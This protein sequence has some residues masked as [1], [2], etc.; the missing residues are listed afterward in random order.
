MPLLN[1]GVL[2][3]GAAGGNELQAVTRRAV[4][5][6]VVVQIGKATVSLSSLLA[7]AEPVVGG[8][9]PI[10]IPVQGVRMVAGAWADYSGQFSAPQVLPGLQNAEYNLKAF[11]VGIPYYLFEGFV[12]Q[13]AEIV[14]IIWARMNDAG[15]Y[16]ADQ[17]ATAL[18]AA[19]SANTSLMPFSIQDLIS[20]SNPTQGNVGNID[21]STNTFWQANSKSIAVIN[22]GSAA[23]SRVNALAAIQ[24]AQKASGGEPPSCLICSQG[25]FMAIAADTIGAESYL[26]DKEGTYATA[27]EG[28]TIAFP[29]LNVGGIPVYA[30]LYA[31]NDTQ[32][33]LP[34]FNYFQAKIHQEASF[35]IAGPE[36]LL[37]QFQLGY[38]MALFV[39]MEFVTS[40]SAAQ[41]TVTAFTGAFAI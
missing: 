14:P 38:V 30:D 31:P 11:V 2:P 33:W 24:Y 7:A 6:G 32:A 26:V 41:S 4:M 8:V 27:A 39:L 21:R 16:T 23:W 10:T 20:T 15:N 25:A 35:A 12:Q 29:A 19:Q 5:P 3:S 28:A 36:S 22:T 13:D 34:N 9:S 40:K 37:P 1:F 17:L 18:W